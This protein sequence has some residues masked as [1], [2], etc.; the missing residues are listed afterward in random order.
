MTKQPVPGAE[1]G[2][3]DRCRWCRRVLPN[4]RIGRPREFCSQACRQWHWV[5]K[6]RA[7]ELQL[8]EDELIVTKGMLDELHDELYVLA[9]A[10]N[11]AEKD[12][13]A[14]AGRETA[15]EL[16]ATLEWLLEAARPLRDRELPSPERSAQRP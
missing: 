2:E 1:R 9:C 10:V 11:D 4:Q 12:L 7:T 5:G 3:P 6:Q 14:G 8:S 16:R 13:R 15:K